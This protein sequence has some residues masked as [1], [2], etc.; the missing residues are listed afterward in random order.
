MFAISREGKG[1]GRGARKR[2]APFSAFL[3][4]DKGEEPKPALLFSL[5]ERADFN[6]HERHLDPKV[7]KKIIRV[8]LHRNFLFAF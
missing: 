8:I 5:S 4:F 2:R 1:A 7:F 3:F 6:I